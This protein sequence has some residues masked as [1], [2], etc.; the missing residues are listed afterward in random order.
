MKKFQNLNPKFVLLPTIEEAGKFIFEKSSNIYIRRKSE[1]L[2]VYIIL[3][4]DIFLKYAFMFYIIR[5]MDS[6]VLG[7]VLGFV[8]LDHRSPCFLSISLV[9]LYA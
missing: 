5:N 7:E 6:Y 3:T 9:G 1:D 4:F 8:L 2:I